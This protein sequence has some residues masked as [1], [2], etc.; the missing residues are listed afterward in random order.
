MENG[1]KPKPKGSSESKDPLR[2][3]MGDIKKLPLDHQQR[4]L[5]RFNW[6]FDFLIACNTDP[7]RSVNIA[8]PAQVRRLIEALEFLE[9]RVGR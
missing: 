3:T 6:L 4:L 8:T 7:A 5:V 2:F 1:N 9:T